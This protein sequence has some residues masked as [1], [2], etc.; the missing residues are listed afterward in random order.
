MPCPR[1]HVSGF[2]L[3]STSTVG[4]HTTST[5]RSAMLRLIRKMFVEFRI[6]FVFIMTMGTCQAFVR[7]LRDAVEGGKWTESGQTI[8]NALQ[9]AKAEKNCV[10]ARRS[11]WEQNP[12][13][14]GKR[15]MNINW[16]IK[17]ITIKLPITPSSMIVMQ[18][19]MDVVRMYAGICG[20]SRSVALSGMCVGGTAA[21]VVADNEFSAWLITARVNGMAES[22]IAAGPQGPRCIFEKVAWKLQQQKIENN[23]S[24]QANE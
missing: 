10:I 17:G 6:S 11:N 2:V 13:L 19:T 18:N 4:V 7:Y 1:I 23:Y 24:V 22:S 9:C 16:Q 14:G 5:N 15:P 3:T 8:S 12:I 21:A 20:I